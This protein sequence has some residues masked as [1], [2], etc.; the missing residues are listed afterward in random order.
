MKI[1]KMA[2]FFS[3]A[4]LSTSVFA[5]VEDVSMFVEYKNGKTSSENIKLEKIS[6]NLL[7]SS[8]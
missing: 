2:A 5:L 1:L 4:L 6:E 7:R 8:S 3:A